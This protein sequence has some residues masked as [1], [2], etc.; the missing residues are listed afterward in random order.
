MVR[1]WQVGMRVQLCDW[2]GKTPA[3]GMFFCPDRTHA[4]HLYCRSLDCGRW[5][6][7]PVRDGIDHRLQGAR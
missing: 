2:C 5:I 3:V 1:R 6:N 7:V 4:A